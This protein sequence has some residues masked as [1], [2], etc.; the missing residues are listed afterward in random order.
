LQVNTILFY[1][2]EITGLWYQTKLFYFIVS[3]LIILSTIGF[4]YYRYFAIK[5]LNRIRT[6]LA[7]D[8]HDEIGTILTRSI[9]R[10]ELMKNAKQ[11]SVD[12]LKKVEHQ[13]RGAV[14]SFRNVLWSLNTDNI[15]TSDFVGRINLTLGDVFDG[16]NFSFL[17]TNLSSSNYFQ[18]PI[19]IKRNVLLI[20]KE[21]AHNTIKHSNGD[22]FEVV[23]RSERGK[24]EILVADNGSNVHGDVQSEG[25]GLA[26]ITKRVDSMNGQLEIE[27][28]E[29]GFFVYIYI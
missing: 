1:L 23:I 25:M 22:F 2:I 6:D 7:N 28:G 29:N 8:I 4:F 16:T 17:V 19:H 5:E 10:I 14:Q 21:L 18:R 24:W 15:R 12:D 11:V 26:S 9:M 3:C 20:I 27:K 13:L